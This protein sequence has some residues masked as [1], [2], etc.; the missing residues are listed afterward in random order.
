MKASHLSGSIDRYDVVVVGAGPYGLS[1]AAHVRGRGLKVAIFGRPLE[2]WRNHMPD[3]MLLR[4][5]WWASNLSDPSGRYRFERFLGESRYQKGYPMSREAFVEYGLW[6]QKRAV[7]DLDE[8]YV[9]SIERHRDAFLLTLADGRTVMSSSVIVALGLAYY[10]HRPAEFAHLPSYL[11]SHS[12]DHHDFSRF[13][14][15][16]IIVVGG[17]QS[18]IEYAALLHEAG[19][20]VHLVSRRPIA[21]RDPDRAN[22]RTAFEKMLAPNASVA[23]GWENWILDRAP[24]L[25]YRF[26]QQRKDDY[27]SNYLSGGADWLRGRVIGS[28]H[29]H[30]GH[31]VTAIEA[32][33]ERVDATISDGD[34]VSADHVMLATGYQVDLNRLTMIHPSLRARI[35]TDMAVPIL[36]QWFE[37]T[38]PGLYFTGL[39]S[40]RA[41]GPLYRFVAGCHPTAKRI[42]AAVTRHAVTRPRAVASFSW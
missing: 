41:F 6:F 12:C 7:P 32:D 20:S 29:L 31:T 38:V 28:V 4:S 24:Y 18:A 2:L 33:G 16:Q 26:P 21:W 14:G 8:T 36:N 35:Q 42:A 27:N 15:Q 30:A 39:T 19:A 17:G 40:L 5:H 1:T 25:F 34:T 23:P 22:G 37:S 13:G 11:V 9:S 3:G 10:S